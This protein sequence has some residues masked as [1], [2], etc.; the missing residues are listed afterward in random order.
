MTKQRAA[1]N[2]SSVAMTVCLSL[3]G[4]AW[5]ATAPS[6]GQ[7]A[8]FSV[9]G[10]SDVNNT[11]SS[12]LYG[13]LGVSPGSVISGFPPGQVIGGGTHTADAVAAQARAD[14]TAAYLQLAG[15]VATS[16]LSGIDLAG[17]TLT[18][19]VYR[20][21]SAALLS[22]TLTLDA[23][24]DPNAV[25]VFQ[26]GSTL[27]TASGSRVQ[28][29]NAG[30]NCNVFWQVGSS[31][32]LGTTTT[33]VGNLLALTSITLRTG[34]TVSG[35]VLVRNGSATL[36]ANDVTA[37]SA[38]C[39]AVTVTP[40]T[41][42]A[43][44][45]GSSYT[46]AFTATGGTG[47]WAWS[48]TA[49][50]LPAGLTLT[51]AGGLSGTPTLAGS[52]SFT[53]TASDANACAG[54]QGLSL[55]I[56]PTG[57]AAGDPHLR[58][59]DGLA[60]EF[61]ACGDFVLLR[62]GPAALEVQVHQERWHDTQ[63]SVNTEV[64][65]QVNGHRVQ[66]TPFAATCAPN[67]TSTTGCVE[68]DGHEITFSCEGTDQAPGCLQTAT[69]PNGGR[70]EHRVAGHSGDRHAKKLATPCDPALEPACRPSAAPC[71]T[72]FTL[73]LGTGE[74]VETCVGAGYLNLDVE[75]PYASRGLT[76]GLLGDADG[77]PANDLQGAR[78]ERLP[79][80]LGFEDFY[81]RFGEHW[82]VAPQASLFAP[83]ASADRC[84]S[85]PFRLDELSP[86]VRDASAQTCR[87]LGIGEA[88]L[89]ACTMDVALLGDAAAFSFVGLA[90]P[91]AVVTL[92]DPAGPGC[93]GCG[94]T[95]S[96]PMTLALMLA[97]LA[98]WAHRRRHP[99]P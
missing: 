53:V 47:P 19:G 56:N 26:T 45:A 68:V 30:S 16:D 9:L 59:L 95:G 15:Q 62:A 4:A 81:L 27:T 42:A 88:N 38:V 97:G 80:N 94:A 22:G 52:S 60:Y 50:A 1:L 77:D 18:A 10:G 99:A 12:R 58:T 57:G 73:Q 83:R 32:T 69:L 76:S 78:G 98:V 51:A 96:S 37:C 49:G 63:T 89:E 28:V 86:Q 44:T 70:L 90:A 40:A 64:A 3:S 61:Q 34:A 35:R 71:A 7:A 93:E 20:Y 91:R 85:R 24:G 48:V 31:A 39:G 55:V 67:A 29:I 75:V 66:L 21:T 2:V 41:L 54:S 13:D 87:T 74:R 92:T 72:S 43:G 46:Q 14:T 65:L 6:L 84:P 5:A 23:Q 11:G 25:F 33:F 8:S 17:L 79:L 82:R 36:D